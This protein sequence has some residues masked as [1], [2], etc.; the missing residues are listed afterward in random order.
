MLMSQVQTR[1]CETR[2]STE[3][4]LKSTL[5]L[6]LVHTQFSFLHLYSP[7]CAHLASVIQADLP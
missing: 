2:T 3:K 1:R 5:R 4:L 6:V 7:A